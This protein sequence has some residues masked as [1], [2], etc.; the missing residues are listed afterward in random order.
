MRNHP[1]NR[2]LLATLALVAWTAGT[3][4]A[5]DAPRA[6][7][8]APVP[9]KLMTRWAK[10]VSPDNV[11]PEYPR[12]QMV[13]KEWR[14]LNGLWDYAINPKAEAAPAAFDGKIL[15]PFPVESALSGVAKQVGPENKLWYRR[16][17]TVPPEWKGQRVLLHFGAVDWEATVTVNGKAAG[18]HKGGFDPFSFDVTDQLAAEGEQT[19][20]VE[21]AD[22]SDASYQPRGKQVRKPGGIFYTPTTGIWQTVW[23]EPVPADGAIRD[24]RITPDADGGTVAIEARSGQTSFAAASRLRAVA[25]LNG[26]VVATGEVL[27]LDDAQK[28]APLKVTLVIPKDK[29]KLWSPDAPV[30]YDLTVSS[31][32]GL[33]DSRTADEVKSYFA[34]RKLSVAKDDKG[35]PRLLLNDKPVFQYGPLDQGFWPDGLY[36]APTDAA[37]LYDL[38]VTKRLGFNMVR[39]HVKV[40]PARWYHHCDRLGLLVWQD[41]PSGDR[42][43]PPNAAEDHKR[44]PESMAN[45]DREWTNIIGALRH[46]PCIVMWVPFNEGWG[47]SETPRVVEMTKKLDPTRWVNNA[48]GWTDRGVG[49]VLDLHVYP[50]PTPSKAAVKPR[51]DRALVLGEFGGLGLPIKGHTWQDEKNWGYRSYTSPEALT[52]AYVGLLTRL[53]PLIGDPGYCAAVY[54]QTTDVETEVNGLMTYDRAV[55]KVDEKQAAEAAKRLFGP[56]PQVVTLVKDAREAEAAWRYTLDKPADGWERADFDDSAWK[57]GPGGF[58]TRMTPGTVVRTEWSTKQIWVRRTIELPATFDPARVFLQMHHDEDADVYLNGVRAAQTTGYTTDYSLF[59]ISAEAR[60]ALK[61]GKNVIAIRCV[62][63][64][65]GQYID[66]GV[67]EV[68]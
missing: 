8:W 25:T 39:K 31:I 13:R 35:T 44:T 37:L 6:A 51:G 11:L 7:K 18:T 2:T 21:V 28:A 22:P 40:E 43:I 4:A 47:Q 34:V 30:L 41:M 49:D 27:A 48:S 60:K 67:V 1:M 58:G 12:P 16:T 54:T 63:N 38:E 68:K 59:P 62:Q 45:Y 14:N 50:G 57:Q 65:G 61:P 9:G 29:L 52:E 55:I 66:A 20:V 53:H 56:P 10:D 26:D 32:I 3:A 5:Q 15:V 33:K 23:I 46:F 42:H 17:F 19:V 36:T 24:L 64:T